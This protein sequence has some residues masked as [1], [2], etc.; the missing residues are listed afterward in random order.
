LNSILLIMEG[1][2]QPRFWEVDFFRGLA[3]V[4]ML[5]YHTIFDLNYFGIHNYILDFGFWFYLARLTAFIFVLIVGVSLVLSYNRNCELRN[6]SQFLLKLIKRGSRIFFLGLLITLTTYLLIGDGFIIFG[7]LH[8]I[9]FSIVISFPFI[10]LYKFNI[11]LGSF[12]ILMG[13]YVQQT[14]VNFPW[15]LWLGFSF[16]NFYTLDFFPLFPWFGVILI[17]ISLGNCLYCNYE[18]GFALPEWSNL[19]LVRSISTLGKKSLMIYLFHQP[20]VIIILLL[21]GKALPF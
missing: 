16:N 20:I 12:F 19:L 2:L 1:S 18:R 5:L 8:F 4:L 13:L 15:L 3:V 6:D 9:G 14:T 7:V 17:G 10:R 21:A 11:I